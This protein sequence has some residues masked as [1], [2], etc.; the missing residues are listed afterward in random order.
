MDVPPLEYRFT[1]K[2]LLV[3]HSTTSKEAAKECAKRTFREHDQHRDFAA[4]VEHREVGTTS[5]FP[6]D[7]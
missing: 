4:D 6:Q 7:Q 5:G 3:G 2:H 1:R